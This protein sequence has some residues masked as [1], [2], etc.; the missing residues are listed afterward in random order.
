MNMFSC[1]HGRETILI[2][3]EN[4]TR[5]PNLLDEGAIPEGPFTSDGENDNEDGNGS[6]N[7]NESDNDFEYF[8]DG[9]MLDDEIDIS[10]VK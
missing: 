7:R 2:Y 8:A 5:E 9:D 3:V 1:N 10:M 4:P 6:G